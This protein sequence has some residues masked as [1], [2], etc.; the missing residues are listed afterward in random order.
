MDNS[1]IEL[2]Q[3]LRPIQFQC[4]NFPYRESRTKWCST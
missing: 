3:R 2:L 4:P 1:L